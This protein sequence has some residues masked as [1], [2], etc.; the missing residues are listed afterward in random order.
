MN[1]HN[2]NGKSSKNAQLLHFDACDGCFAVF[3][4][5]LKIEIVR[6]LNELR[7]KT[8][9]KPKVTTTEQP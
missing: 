2:N 9:A 5:E 1:L 7:I 6:F 8:H 4:D 3:L